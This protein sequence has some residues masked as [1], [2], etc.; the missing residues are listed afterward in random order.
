MHESLQSEMNLDLALAAQ[1][2]A[3]LLPT[4]CPDNCPHQTAAARNRMCATLGGDFYDFIRINDDQ[5]AIAVG[6]VVGHGVRAALLMSKIMGFLRS[7]PPTIARP[8]QFVTDLNR[9]LLDLADKSGTPVPCSLFYAVIDGPTGMGFFVNAGHPR[10]YLC[11]RNV[12]HISPLGG[13]NILLGVEDFEPNEACHTF[14][15]GERMVLYTDG[16]MDACNAKGEIFG[17]TRFFETISRSATLEPA[18]CANAVF[19]AV[20]DFRKEAPQ[21]DDQTIVVVDRV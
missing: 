20:D 4:S 19:E 18:A 12:C 7:R 13:R 11:D 5:T 6:D 2:Q 15:P 14:S 8:C 16:L 9:M 17:E 3:A 21:T 10:P 1:L